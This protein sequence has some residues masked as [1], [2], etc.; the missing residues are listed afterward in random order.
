MA[1]ANS[2]LVGPTTQ[3]MRAAVITGPQQVQIEHLDVPQP[4]A[5]QVRIRLH[6]SGVC[7]SNLPFWEGRPWFQYP[8]SPGSPGHEGWGTVEA[9]GEGVTSVA[10]GDQ[11]AAMTSHAFAEYDLADASSVV[12]LPPALRN[13]PFPGEPL[14]CA[15]NVFRRSDIQPGQTVAIIGIGFLGAGLTRLA[16][17]AGARVVAISRRPYALA[18]AQELGADVTIPLDDQ[19]SIVHDVFRLTAGEGADRVIEVTGLQRPLDL[20][21]E[22]TRVRGRLVI[23]GYHQDGLRQV[24]MQLWNWRGLDVINAHEREAAT[25]VSGIQAAVE[26]VSRGVL[27]PARLY[28]HVFQ[29]GELHSA[30]EMARRRPDGFL[31]ALVLT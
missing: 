14:G 18:V 15:M 5:G 13:R 19:G 6:G 2:T 9:V 21:G 22:L 16:S 31:K 8:A 28:T 30:L 27:N 20:A 29:L 7:G 23:A 11:V 3:T 4:K 12:V 25:Y 10:I 1:G 24:N 26:A 17:R